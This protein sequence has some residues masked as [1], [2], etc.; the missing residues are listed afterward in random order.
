M[1]VGEALKKR[2]LEIAL[3]ELAACTLLGLRVHSAFMALKATLPVAMFLMLLQ[4]MYSLDL[5]A[6]RSGGHRR[7]ARFLGWCSSST[8]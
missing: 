1:G 5:S 7:R 4:P 6:L 2:I 3:I 8:S